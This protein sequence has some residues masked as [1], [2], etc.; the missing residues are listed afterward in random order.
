MRNWQQSGEAL[1]CDNERVIIIIILHEKT[2]EYNSA[3]NESKN[4]SN[5]KIQEF[6]F[7]LAAVSLMIYIIN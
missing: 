7:I 2:L 3:M 6:F 1:E 4:T 5:S